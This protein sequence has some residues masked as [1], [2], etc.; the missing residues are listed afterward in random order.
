MESLVESQFIFILLQFTFT[1]VVNCSQAKINRV[2]TRASPGSEMVET[3]GF[4]VILVRPVL[5]AHTKTHSD[6]GH[7]RG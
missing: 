5:S 6:P 2:S 1:A 4:M 3:S 7:I